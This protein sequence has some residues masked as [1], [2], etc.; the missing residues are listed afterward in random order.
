MNRAPPACLSPVITGHFT[1]LSLLLSV[2]LTTTS[3]SWGQGL[4][5]YFNYFPQLFVLTTQW[6]LNSRMLNM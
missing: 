1:Y 4:A 2:F 3:R 5:D 6:A